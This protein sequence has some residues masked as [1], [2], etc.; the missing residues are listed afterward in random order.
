MPG[1]RQ[2]TQDAA[3]YK[4]LAWSPKGDYL[5]ATRCDILSGEI[6]CNTASQTVLV[7]LSSG[8]AQPISF[9][10]LTPNPV[11]VYHHAWSPDG[12][13]LLLHVGE[14]LPAGSSQPA[15]LSSPNVI[16]DPGDGALQ[17]IALPAATGAIGWSQSSPEKL[18]I[19]QWPTQGGSQPGVYAWY[20][21]DNGETVE[22]TD[23]PQ[24]RWPLG[25]SADGK[26]LLTIEVEEAY[27]SCGDIY[28]VAL[29]APNGFTL[30]QP[31][32]C[33]VVWSW[34]GSKTAY[35]TYA[36]SQYYGDARLMLANADGSN[37]QPLF[38]NSDLSGFYSV[39][40]SPDGKHIAFSLRSGSLGGGY[41]SGIYI[42]AAPVKRQP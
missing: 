41:P 36:H 13:R 2:L 16:F 31:D 30:T 33:S 42:A 40:W 10:A 8:E 20:D 9:G 22:I 26:K 4:D 14:R 21:L 29:G 23:D 5:A 24:N 35:T 18:L 39:A 32:V 7:A 19:W 11:T 25:L 3:F 28:A 6:K 12:D 37:P 15:R 27:R 1:V 38:Q 17:E 34:D